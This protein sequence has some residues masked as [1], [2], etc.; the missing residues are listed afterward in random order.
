MGLDVPDLDD[1]TFEDLL[2]DVRKRI[3]VHSESWTDHNASDPGITMLEMLAWVAESDIYEL[4]RVA[5]RHVLKYLRLLGVR[6]HPPRPATASVAVS[7]RPTAAAAAHGSTLPEGTRLSVDD[8]GTSRT[9]ETTQ[10]V[11]LAA[12]D[13]AAVVSETPSGRVDHSNANESPGL[14]FLPFGPDAAENSAMY[15]GF[16]TDPF[17]DGS[18]LD[19]FVDFHD[20]NLP[21]PAE[22]GDEESPFEPS[23]RV[24]WEHCTDY[25]AFYD[26]TVWQPVNGPDADAGGSS[27]AEFRDETDHLYG[28]GRVT[29]PEPAGWTGAS[30]GLFDVDDELVWLRARL[31]TAGHEIPPQVD[32]VET[33]VV[34]AVHGRRYRDERLLRLRDGMTADTARRTDVDA[35]TTTAQPNQEFAIPRAP[36]LA[37]DDSRTRAGDTE[38]LQV[39]V[40]GV[41]WEQVEDFDAS[42]PDHRAYVVDHE[43]GVV[44]FGDGVR[45]EVPKPGQPVRLTWYDHGGG[46]A[47]N[48]A[49]DADWR[50]ADDQPSSWPT[51]VV[52]DDLAVRPRGPAAGGTD[53]EATD[54]ALARLKSDLRTPYRAVTAED[55]RYL[56]THTPGL[57][58]GRAA[59][60]VEGRAADDECARHG[61]VTVTVVPHSPRDR[62]EASQG[63]KRAVETH[64]GRHR[65][66]TDELAVVTPLYV[67]VT[68]EAV[69]M[70]ED[71]H[72]LGAT[73][74]S[75]ETAL[76]GFLDPLSGFDGDGWPFGRPVYRSEVY[77]TVEDVDGVDCVADVELSAR[78]PGSRIDAGIGVPQTAL[79][80]L[81]NATV[82]TTD[83]RSRCGEW[84]R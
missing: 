54:A 40:G 52:P 3:P 25:D 84:S 63:F 22:H 19:L 7:L 83:D 11:V 60:H 69:V 27:P 21:D 57:R 35:G 24:V 76:D 17:A 77:E 30:H 81:D 47:G 61:H 4:D 42:G 80:Y 56:A 75:V 45:G 13:V 79:V 41:E 26:P 82:T 78:E 72:A 5:E 28:G 51:D 46:S 10:S 44:R 18:R 15:L 48:V 62:P 43:R 8:A 59:V 9:F 49:A 14:H 67:P 64:L 12:A 71:G 32:T 65:L 68:I 53:A 39:T 37:A 34:R 2:T 50:V 58:V 20:E 66:L 33:G 6:P 55:Y 1:R 29:I 23:V 73:T 38:D 36:V 31:A 70:V 74:D 16:D